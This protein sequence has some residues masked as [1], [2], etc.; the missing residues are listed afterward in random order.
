MFG[1]SHEKSLGSVVTYTAVNCLNFLSKIS[2]SFTLT[3]I[4]IPSQQI[5]DLIV[6]KI[7]NKMS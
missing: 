2:S 3:M 7:Q 4:K 5:F 6:G 1:F